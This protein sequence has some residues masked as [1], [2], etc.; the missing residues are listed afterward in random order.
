MQ[1]LVKFIS[2][3]LLTSCID[4]S[5]KE[6]NAVLLDKSKKMTTVLRDSLGAISFSIPVRFDTAF[7]WTNR[8]D[9][10][11]PCDREYYRYQPKTLPVFKESGFFYEIP[12]ILI[13]QFTIIHSGYFPFHDGDT[14]KNWVRH[15]NF[16]S[17]ISNDPNNGIVYSDTIEKVGDRYFSIVYLNGFDNERQK[18]FAKVVALTTI[19]SNE[20]EFHYDIN[21]KDTINLKDYYQNSIRLL[22]T[23]RISNGI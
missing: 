17:R 10:G 14:S 20:I 6:A 21:T 16:I 5:D 13:E 15:G 4:S 18:C 2:V 19:K 22:K 9:C 11:K 3:I 12:D 7:V 23:I 1:H 8:S